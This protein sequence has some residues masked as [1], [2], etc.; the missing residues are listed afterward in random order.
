MEESEMNKEVARL[1]SLIDGRRIKPSSILKLG[2]TAALVFLPAVPIKAYLDSAKAMHQKQ[3][4]NEIAQ[5]KQESIEGIFDM[6]EHQKH[7]ELIKTIS[8]EEKV[9]EYILAAFIDEHE[10]SRLSVMHG[11]D[12][13]FFHNT[14]VSILGRN[15]GVRGPRLA[16]PEIALRASA[17]AYKDCLE[18]CGNEEEALIN[19]G[20][21]NQ[22]SPGCSNEEAKRR[23]RKAKEE[24]ETA[25]KCH[26]RYESIKEDPRYAELIKL[27]EQ[28]YKIDE[29]IA[30]IPDDPT[31][32][33]EWGT[34]Y[35]RIANKHGKSELCKRINK[36]AKEEFS[37]DDEFR[38]YL[39]AKHDNEEARWWVNRAP[40]DDL[41]KRALKIKH[42]R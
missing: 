11:C 42:S 17:R 12:P 23:V 4:D 35:H 34:H 26:E 16:N 41:V 9:P 38:W 30:Q 2:L 5:I 21:Q 25:Q 22:Y 31:K 36:I 39:L 24:A 18:A 19:H 40:Y 15:V 33:M 13:I 10:K 6:D 8:E 7:E 37:R 28:V 32:E 3:E 27:V 14:L 29:E 1:E 20:M